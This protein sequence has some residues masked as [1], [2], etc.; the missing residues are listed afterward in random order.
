MPQIK[1]IYIFSEQATCEIKSTGGKWKMQ[2]S[3]NVEEQQMPG[4]KEKF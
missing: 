1:C 2:K 3:L 4:Q